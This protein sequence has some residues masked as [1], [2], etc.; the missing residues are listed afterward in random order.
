MI[1]LIGFGGTA[2]GR[3]LSG[4]VLTTVICRSIVP[5]PPPREHQSNRESGLQCSLALLPNYDPDPV[6]PSSSLRPRPRMALPAVTSLRDCLYDRAHARHPENP[7]GRGTYAATTRS[8][9]ITR[10]PASGSESI[11]SFISVLHR[12]RPQ[13]SS[14]VEQSTTKRAGQRHQEQARAERTT[15]CS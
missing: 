3:D 9:S 10:R 12:Q 13:C 4:L 15:R 7:A 8:S 1:W 2:S 6:R 11:D 14:C 5:K